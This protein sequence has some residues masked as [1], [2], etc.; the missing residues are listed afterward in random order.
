MQELIEL[1]RA[2]FAAQKGGGLHWEGKHWNLKVPMY[3]R[4]GAARETIPI[5]IAAVN[6][7]MIGAAGAAADGLVGHPI[8]TRRWHREV[9][10]PGLREAEEKNGHG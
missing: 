10:L 5:W 4:P 9:T 7:G 2:A 1:M 8:A 3:A 6:R